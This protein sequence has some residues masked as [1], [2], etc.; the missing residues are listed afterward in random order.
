M[1]KYGVSCKCVEGHPDMDGMTKLA[2]GDLKCGS[3]GRVY[4]NV[5]LKDQ[6]QLKEKDASP[7]KDKS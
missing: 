5:K 7:V 2:S 3:C 4:A 6:I 1:E